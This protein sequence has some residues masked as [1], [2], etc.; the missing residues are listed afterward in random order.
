MLSPATTGVELGGSGTM[1]HPA[2]LAI[3]ERGLLNLLV[4]PGMLPFTTTGLACF[5]SGTGNPTPM[6]P[7]RYSRQTI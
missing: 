7:T 1:N 3:A 4:H 5:Y 6:T 2:G